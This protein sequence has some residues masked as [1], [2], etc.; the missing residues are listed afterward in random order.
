MGLAENEMSKIEPF[1]SNRPPVAPSSGTPDYYQ[2]SIAQRSSQ[3]FDQE[4][5]S[6]L[7][8]RSA[9]SQ[10]QD[11]RDTANWEKQVN[12]KDGKKA[13]TKRK[14][15]D[16]SSPMEPHA[17]VPSQLD[18]RNTVV[19][20]RKGK[21]T[22]TEPS[23]GLPVKSGEQTNLFSISSQMEHFLEMPRANK[24][25]FIEVTKGFDKDWQFNAMGS[26]FDVFRRHRSFF[27][28]Y[29]YRDF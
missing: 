22:K 19:N 12:Q 28:T 20:T 13:T 14:R 4:S 24:D 27:C 23:D 1:A 17:D 7:D 9:N 2:G 11:R 21:M 5:P 3:S 29:F 10:S 25:L 16:T 8:S 26:E 6:S 15:G 18:T